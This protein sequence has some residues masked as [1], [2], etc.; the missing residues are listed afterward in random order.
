M[1][2]EMH[3][4]HHYF[5]THDCAGPRKPGGTGIEWNLSASGLCWW[6]SFNKWKQTPQTETCKLC[7][8]L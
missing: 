1:F 8:M 7:Q 3:L 4:H 6:Y 5:R 2:K